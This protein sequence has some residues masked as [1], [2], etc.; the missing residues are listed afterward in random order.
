MREP[1]AKGD[2]EAEAAEADAEAATVGVLVSPPLF[3]APPS[4]PL[5]SANLDG[6]LEVAVMTSHTG[7]CARRRLRL[8]S[9][10]HRHHHHHH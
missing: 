1:E 10:H 7:M 3:R 9:R 5:C 8:S 6:T 2:S 4:L